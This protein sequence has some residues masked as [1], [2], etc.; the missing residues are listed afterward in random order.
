MAA[1][2]HAHAEGVLA[3]IEEAMSEVEGWKDKLIATGCDG[4][5]VNM[6]KNHSVTALLK[7][8]VPHLIAM[9]CVSHRLELGVLDA[10][11][12]RE[13]V[14]FSDIKA[15]LLH[16]HKHYHDYSAKALRELKNLADAMMT[17]MVRPANLDG[18]RWM[19]HLS[20]SL[21]ILLKPETYRVFVTHF[22]DI[23]EGGKGSADVQGRAK[24]IL[25]HLK[26]EK[27]MHFM[28]FLQ[29]VLV[30]LSD[31]SLQFQRDTCSIPDALESVETACLRLV[32]LQQR[33]GEHL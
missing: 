9:H 4:A 31:L 17:K 21:T 23:V 22:E 25:K 12:E 10:L 19:P 2:E 16:L 32:A 14:I 6:G 11:K 3:A 5:S 24:N 1:V 20:R 13:S 18:T 8:D 33:P 26:S 30:I 15:A 27:L 29:D 28:H 7:R